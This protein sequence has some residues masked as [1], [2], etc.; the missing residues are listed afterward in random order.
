MVA[1]NLPE[2]LIG[3]ARDLSYAVPGR[4]GPAK[5]NETVNIRLRIKAAFCR[6]ARGRDRTVS[7]F[8][9]ANEMN[10]QSGF[11]GNDSNRKV[12]FQFHVLNN[13]DFR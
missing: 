10:V 4:N 13:I 6:C 12:C 11:L 5:Q 2:L 8:P 9:N 7:S 1:Q 3:Q